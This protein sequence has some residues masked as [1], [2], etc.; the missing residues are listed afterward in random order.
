MKRLLALSLLL[1]MA[2]CSSEPEQATSYQAPQSQDLND[3]DLDGVINA[4]DLCLETPPNAVVG[5]NGC[6][7]ML[8]QELENELLV[9]FKHDSAS[10]EQD[11]I[12]ELEIYAAFLSQNP[13]LE[14]LIQAYASE[15][16][17]QAYNQDLSERRA[18][19]VQ[20][21]LVKL[22]VDKNRI[23]IQAVGEAQSIN[24]SSTQQQTLSRYARVATQHSEQQAK[25]K[26]S[27]FREQR[28]AL[29]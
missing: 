9:F 6:E 25:L 5:N 3:D 13:S 20:Q 24:A 29:L 12:N 14:V 23:E 1:V 11:F 21:S 19:R 22:G 28:G 16:G 18:N 26:W 10:I 4:R 7:T 17:S 15:P 2:A 8:S 27:V